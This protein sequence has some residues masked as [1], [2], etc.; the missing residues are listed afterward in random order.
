[1]QARRTPAISLVSL[2]NSGIMKQKISSCV[3]MM[4]LL[5]GCLVTHEN[6]IFSETLKN[7]YT[8]V[9]ANASLVIHSLPFAGC[10]FKR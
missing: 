2:P 4:Q 5:K 7:L 6:K 10:L 8:C 1:M 9:I 3:W